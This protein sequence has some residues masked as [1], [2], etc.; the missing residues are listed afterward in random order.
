MKHYFKQILKSN[1]YSVDAVIGSGGEATVYK[2]FHELRGHCAVK[3]H[4]TIVDSEEDLPR[5]AHD[6]LEFARTFNNSPFLVTLYDKFWDQ[7]L[8]TIWEL[9]EG[10]L[11]DAIRS[12]EAES[13]AQDEVFGYLQ[14]VASGLDYIHS[15]NG[16]H[17]DI[18]PSNLLVFP[19]DFVKIGDLGTSRI[20]S[21]LTTRHTDM[22]SQLYSLPTEHFGASTRERDLFAFAVVYAELRL[23]RHPYGI[24]FRSQITNLA[25]NTPNLN[26]LNDKER[27]AIEAVLLGVREPDSLLAWLKQLCAPET[28]SAPQF[29]PYLHALSELTAKS[30]LL[31]SELKRRHVA[32]HPS[33]TA[34]P[35][36]SRLIGLEPIFRRRSRNTFGDLSIRK[37]FDAVNVRNAVSHNAESDHKRTP[38]EMLEAAEAI[39]VATEL[40]VEAPTTPV[41]KPIEPAKS[42]AAEIPEVRK[43]PEL[44][45]KNDR[46]EPKKFAPSPSRPKQ[47]EESKQKGKSAASQ[48]VDPKSLASPAPMNSEQEATAV[49]RQQS[50]RSA[51]EISVD[52]E[53]APPWLLAYDPPKGSVRE[54]YCE[55]VNDKLSDTGKAVVPILFFA[56]GLS[57]MQILKMLGLSQT[58]VAMHCYLWTL[59]R[60]SS[61]NANDAISKCWQEQREC[62][63]ASRF[64]TWIKAHKASPCRPKS[65]T[66]DSI[67]RLFFEQDLTPS[68]MVSGKS[69]GKRKQRKNIG[70]MLWKDIDK[71]GSGEISLEVKWGIA[72][73]RYLINNCEEKAKLTT[74]DG[75]RFIAVYC[76][77]NKTGKQKK[78]TNNINA[79]QVS[80][81][82]EAISINQLANSAL[83]Q[84]L[85]AW[86]TI[87][88]NFPGVSKLCKKLRS[89][90]AKAPNRLKQQLRE[91]EASQ[92]CGGLC[93]SSGIPILY[94]PAVCEILYDFVIA[95]GTHEATFDECWRIV[96]GEK[97]K[98]RIRCSNLPFASPKAILGCG[99][100]SRGLNSKQRL[101]ICVSFFGGSRHEQTASASEICQLTSFLTAFDSNI[102][103]TVSV[104]QKGKVER[105]I[106]C[107]LHDYNWEESHEAAWSR[108]A[109][110][111]WVRFQ[112]KRPDLK[113][114]RLG[115]ITLPV[116]NSHGTLGDLSSQSQ[117]NAEALIPDEQATAWS[118]MQSL[119]RRFFG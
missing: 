107:H 78:Q 10:T 13:F 92:T 86:P 72:K 95:H 38:T 17:G 88:K 47:T 105:Y 67:R 84:S 94:S 57:P 50:D 60:N 1:G 103:A 96:G 15:R 51:G 39:R 109:R 101:A 99:I 45:E 25:A 43:K 74:S 40:L 22:R 97:I 19:G 62:L 31:E 30:A 117:E 53:S 4:H 14:N 55:Y 6:E 41:K 34:V 64:P 28:T 63:L 69:T 29:S 5:R 11:R 66:R 89:E 20:M 68:Q 21:S 18:K 71:I 118:K 26:G 59:T 35:G 93:Q 116:T 104:G 27:R 48:D 119:A 81:Q 52:L 42:K 87:K 54:K 8:F 111:T 37:L 114:F 12:R 61:T 102:F 98:N 112:K 65:R 79:S 56:F 24:D 77:L 75:D 16:A 7:Y 49:P 108:A 80:G 46:T 9:A 3:V 91:L 113:S 110:D 23:G 83:A 44:E 106:D 70:G 90:D 85:R 58:I 73:G 32:S 33:G 36:L 115:A 82:A 100:G 2:A 76:N